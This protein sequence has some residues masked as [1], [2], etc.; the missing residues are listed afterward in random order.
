MQLQLFAGRYQC[1]NC[2]ANMDVVHRVRQFRICDTCYA[3]FVLPA[4][5]N[6][7]LDAVSRQRVAEFWEWY[8]QMEARYPT[9]SR[10]VH[11]A[12]RLPLPP[13]DY[14]PL[15]DCGVERPELLRPATG[16][17]LFGHQRQT[18]CRGCE[19]RLRVE[20]VFRLADHIAPGRDDETWLDLL[21]RSQREAFDLGV[22]PD[23]WFELRH[24]TSKEG[25]GC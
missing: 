20:S 18:H 16:P 22:L 1:Q 21:Y 6:N 3:N 14:L 5:A 15:C 4:S 17:S 7:N 12:P 13:S 11:F 8:Y 19:A 24:S 9:K 10:Q 2:G 25:G 23:Y